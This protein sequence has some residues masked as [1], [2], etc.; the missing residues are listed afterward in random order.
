MGPGGRWADLGFRDRLIPNEIVR[1][2]LD[3]SP[4]WLSERRIKALILDLDNT[5]VPYGQ[6]T[7]CP[8]LLAHIRALLHLGVRAV[9]LSNAGPRRT[10]SVA[11]KMEIPFVASAGKPGLRGYARALAAVGTAPEHTAAVGDQIFRDV[12]GARTAGCYAV[13]VPPMT[14]RDFPGTRILRFFERLVLARL[15]RRGE[16]DGAALAAWFKYSPTRTET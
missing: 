1:S 3:I 15:A 4:D 6:S 5:L 2:V 10:R 13:L 8:D 7:V 12:I 11:A 14:P 9:I 16:I